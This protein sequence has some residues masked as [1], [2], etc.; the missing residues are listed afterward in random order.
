MILLFFIFDFLLLY[1]RFLV[2]NELSKMSELEG[3]SLTKRVREGLV[4]VAGRVGSGKS[5]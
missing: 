1:F 3:M 5:G 2:K 4:E